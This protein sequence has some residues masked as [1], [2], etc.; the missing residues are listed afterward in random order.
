MPSAEL[1]SYLSGMIMDKSVFNRQIAD[2]VLSL[3]PPG[4]DADTFSDKLF[5]LYGMHLYRQ[6]IERCQNSPN[7]IVGTDLY[8]QIRAL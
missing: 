2:L 3:D 1:N 4:S 5:E 8:P 6:Y 7:F